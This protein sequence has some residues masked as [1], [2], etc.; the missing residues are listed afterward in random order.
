MQ[1]RINEEL[2]NGMFRFFIKAIIRCSPVV[3]IIMIWLQSSYFHPSRAAEQLELPLISKVMIGSLFE[4]MHFF[5]FGILF[6]LL[7]AALYTYSPLT[8]RT[9]SLMLVISILYA[10]VDEVHQYFVPFR[11]ASLFDLIK[12]WIGILIVLFIIKRWTDKIRRIKIVS[13]MKGFRNS[14]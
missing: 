2:C 8:N 5:Q 10:I 7:L 12:N 13:Y 11:S 1:N 3:Y 14:L 9:I 6:L 4:F